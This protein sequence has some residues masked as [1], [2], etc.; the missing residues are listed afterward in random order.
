MLPIGNLIGARNIAKALTTGD[1]QESLANPISP[2]SRYIE[3]GSYI[4]LANAAIQ[5][6]FG[7]IGKTFKN[8]FVYVAGQN[9]LV[10][11]KFTGFDPEVN[12]DKQVNGVPSVGIEYTPYPS[13]R[14]FQLGVNF[15]L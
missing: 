8:V 15:S 1:V 2:S 7:N 3:N 14:S 11:T 9:L 13:A 12:T 10:F 4:K 5:Y 6:N